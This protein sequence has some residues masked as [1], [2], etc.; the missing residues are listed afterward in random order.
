MAIEV[1]THFNSVDFEGE[2]LWSLVAIN[3][4]IKILDATFAGRSFLLA[5]KTDFEKILREVDGS[6]PALIEI[7]RQ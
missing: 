3:G 2:V 5:Q 7:L 4:D 6:I 1:K